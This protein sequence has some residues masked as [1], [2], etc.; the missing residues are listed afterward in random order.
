MV[1]GLLALLKQQNVQQ[2][3]VQE[4]TQRD[5]VGGESGWMGFGLLKCIRRSLD[6][7]A[8]WRNKLPYGQASDLLE[9]NPKFV[10][11][12]FIGRNEHE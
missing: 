5:R 9:F 4:H 1:E 11:P 12:H 10:K 8:R 2:I 3:T 7:E 6:H